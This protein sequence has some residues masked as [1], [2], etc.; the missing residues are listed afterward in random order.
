LASGAERA[1]ELARTGEFPVNVLRIGRRLVVST[2]ALLA[3]VEASASDEAGDRSASAVR[4]GL[5]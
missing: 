5:A 1:Y 3:L 4:S 2:S